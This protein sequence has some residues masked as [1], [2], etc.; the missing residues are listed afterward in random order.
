MANP[1]TVLCP[2]CKKKVQYH[3]D[4]VNHRKQ[5]LLTIFTLGMWL[6]MWLAVAFSPTKL[7]NECGGPLW[8]D[9]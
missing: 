5:L 1:K 8:A 6:P 9:T 2:R 3:F 4:P 7:C